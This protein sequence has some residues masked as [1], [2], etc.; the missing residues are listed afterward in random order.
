MPK[1]LP[2]A[3]TLVTCWPLQDTLAS[4]DDSGK[5]TRQVYTGLARRFGSLRPRKGCVHAS[6]DVGPP[7]HWS[8]GAGSSDSAY[9]RP[10]AAQQAHLP[11]PLVPACLPLQGASEDKPNLSLFKNRR[12]QARERCSGACLSHVEQASSRRRALPGAGSR[13]VMAHNTP[14]DKWRSTSLRGKRVAVS[15]R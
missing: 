13:V 6:V 4:H 11:L 10:A 15:R 9:G 7:P 2:P 8:G 3:K 1:R 12:G 14:V 5:R